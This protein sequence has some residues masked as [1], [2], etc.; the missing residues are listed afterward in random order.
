MELKYILDLFEINTKKIKLIIVGLLLS[1]ILSNIFTLNIFTL[2]TYVSKPANI[3]DYLK[4]SWAIPLLASISALI[5]YFTIKDDNFKLERKPQKGD[6]K[7]IFQITTR[8]F[9]VD[10]LKRSIESVKYWAPKYLKEYEIWVVTEPDADPEIDNIKGVK[11]IKVPYE[12]STKNGSKYKTRA[13]EYAKELRKDYDHEKTWIYFMDEESV[14]GEDTILG[15]IDFIENKR[16]VIGQGLII[17]PNFF[18]KNIFTSLADSIRPSADVSIHVFQIKTGFVSWM[19]GSHVLI[20]SDVE[21]QIGWDFGKTWGEDSLFGLKAQ[22]LGYRIEWLKG[23]LYE[24]S[25]FTIKDFLKQRRRWALHS[26]DI[27][28]RKLPLKF[29]LYYFYSLLIWASGLISLTAAIL[30]TLSDTILYFNNYIILAVMPV[31]VTWI[32]SYLVGFYLNTQPLDIPIHYKILFAV[33][34]IIIGSILDGIAIWYA[35]FTMLINRNIAY[36]VIKK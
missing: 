29:K 31:T 23:R 9:N 18:G 22:E 21:Q 19:H 6:Y 27:L 13:L 25:P 16:G 4:I 28:K 30:A 8:G 17:Y 26:F 10:A 3:F 32:G 1:V 2:F 24:Q 33:T 11:I 36:E 5:G 34:S 35:I 15:I 14:V 12:F 7:V 20:R